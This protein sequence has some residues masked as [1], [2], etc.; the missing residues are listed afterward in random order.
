MRIFC[1]VIGAVAGFVVA[2]LLF[3]LLGLGN[4][5]D[6]IM[7]GVLALFVFGPTGAVGGAIAGTKIAIRL[8][9]A[10]S[11]ASTGES[12]GG[13]LASNVLKA[14]GV[15]VALVAVAGALY[16][17]YA[18]S[19]AT[20]WLN[21]NA[22]NPVLQFEVRLPAGHRA[23][24]AGEIAV[25]LQTDLNSMP[26][27]VR[28]ERS[29]QDGDRPVIAGEVELAFRTSYRQLEVR[30]KG[31]ADRVYAITLSGRAPHASELGPWQPLADGSEIRY[32][33]KWPGRE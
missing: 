17:V 19:T 15:V 23:P 29:R 7:S 20:P 12:A 21:P 33:A 2:L 24:A 31:Q 3:E 27:E 18:I 25:E 14:L 28:A 6:L 22:P 10:G 16:S 26:G 8:R 32:R 1:G 9:G 13:G 5:A 30:I 4:R 11:T